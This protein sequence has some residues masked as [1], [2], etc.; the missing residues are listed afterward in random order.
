MATSTFTFLVTV[1]AE[2]ESGKFA[3]RDEIAE[4]LITALEEADP[5][6]IDGIGADSESTYNTVTWEVQEQPKEKR[7]AREPGSI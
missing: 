3:S 6:E 7:K 5:G 4:A 1:E 2:R